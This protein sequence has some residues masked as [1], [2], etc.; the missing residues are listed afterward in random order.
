[1][2]LLRVLQEREFERVGGSATLKVDVRVV[3]ATNADIDA[4]L[5]AGRIREDLYYRLKVV[6]IHVPPLRG[7]PGDLPALAQH[8]LE[9]FAAENGKDLREIHPDVLRAF[10]AYQWPGN[11][12]ELENA[13]ESAVVRCQGQ[14]L[15]V[16]LF[17]FAPQALVRAAEPEV[18]DGRLLVRVGTTMAEVE[19][20]LILATLDSVQ[21]NKAEAAR[22]LGIGTRTLYRRLAEYDGGGG[23]TPAAQ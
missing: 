5:R 1:M 9:R 15:S 16:D 10:D 23:P 2:K 20:K 4:A 8:F 17:P 11:V 21:G 19:K 3:A 7:R 13:I 18:A 12:R 6:T 14:S 22:L